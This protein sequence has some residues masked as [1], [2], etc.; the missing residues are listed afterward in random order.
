MATHKVPQ[1]V[2][3][4]DKLLGPLSLKQLIFTILGLGFGYL[5][6]FFFARVHPIASVIFIPF[7]L[8][9]LVLGLYQRKDQPAEVFLASAIRFYFKP[10]KRI[11][12]QEGYQERVQITAPPKVEHRYTKE[13]TGEEATSRLN[14]LSRLM[15]S[16]GWTTKLADDWQNPQFALATAGDRLVQPQAG[17]QPQYTQPVDMQDQRSSVVAQMIDERMTQAGTVNKQRALETLQHARQEADSAIHQKVINPLPLETPTVAEPEPVAEE[18]NPQPE[19]APTKPES[20]H[21]VQGDEVEISL[22]H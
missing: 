14:T 6:Y 15:D 20:P 9:F 21:T 18:V 19:A 5:T 16:R 17:A 8:F 11:W 7:C 3:A 2:E 1:D 10:R 12:N 13:F 22:H 4:E